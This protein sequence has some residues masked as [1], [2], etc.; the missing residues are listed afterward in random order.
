M[1]LLSIMSAEDPA[2]TSTAIKQIASSFDE[3]L[4]NNILAICIVSK[5]NESWP[6]SIQ[7][8]KHQR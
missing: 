1:L 2:T 8:T 3:L 7:V 6:S 5:G 4:I